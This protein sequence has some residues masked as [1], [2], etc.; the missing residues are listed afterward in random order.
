M[1]LECAGLVAHDMQ[2]GIRT[3]LAADN[4][5]FTLLVFQAHNIMCK[6]LGVVTKPKSIAST[7]VHA[8]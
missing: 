1:V 8:N 2:Y 6:T 3:Y 5:Y 7:H 4:R